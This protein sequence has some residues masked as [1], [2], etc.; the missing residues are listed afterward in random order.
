[1]P[2]LFKDLYLYRYTDDNTERINAALDSLPE[3]LAARKRN[4]ML[5]RRLLNHPGII[6]PEYDWDNGT[7][8]RY[9]VRIPGKCKQATE[10]LRKRKF[11]AS[12]LYY[13]P[14]HEIYDSAPDTHLFVPNTMTISSTI[15]NLWVEPWITDDYIAGAC[16]IILEVLSNE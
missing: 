13:V 10:E 7:I 16:D 14:L 1:M 4:A 8:Y 5:Y 15:L 9:S 3:N 6:H 2:A 11:D 12:N